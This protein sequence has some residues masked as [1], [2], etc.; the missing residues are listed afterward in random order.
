MH[1]VVDNN[2]ARMETFKPSCLSFNPAKSSTVI[3]NKLLSIR[4]RSV[5][6]EGD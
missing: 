4:L 6:L 5:I 3:A 1:C 2:D